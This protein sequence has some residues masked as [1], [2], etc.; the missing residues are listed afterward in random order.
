M[1]TFDGFDIY[2]YI[3]IVCFFRNINLLVLNK[4]IICNLLVHI[5]LFLFQFFLFSFISSVLLLSSQVEIDPADPRVEGVGFIEE[6]STLI[7]GLSPGYSY[8]V[9]VTTV[10]GEQ[11]GPVVEREL[12]TSALLKLSLISLLVSVD[13]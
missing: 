7:R 4:T 2:F 13:D 8:K 1:P 11:T 9:T 10:N 3:Q 12:I 5:L 6:E